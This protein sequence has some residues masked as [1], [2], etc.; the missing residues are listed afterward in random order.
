M[1]PFERQNIIVPN[2]ERRKT[3]SPE[4]KIGFDSGY[5]EAIESVLVDL[6]WRKNEGNNLLKVDENK[7]IIF[8]YDGKVASGYVILSTPESIKIRVKGITKRFLYYFN[9]SVLCRLVEK[10]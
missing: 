6:F 1:T 3:F 4:G 7:D 2:S 8:R 10:L 5:R 9:T